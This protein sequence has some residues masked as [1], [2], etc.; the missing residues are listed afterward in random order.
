MIRNFSGN[1]GVIVDSSNKLIA[2]VGVVIHN[3][4]DIESTATINLIKGSDSI[5]IFET[6]LESKESL[7]LDTKIFLSNGDKI[8]VSGANF[9]LSGDEKDV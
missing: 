4:E 9:V 8:E 1:S 2:L 7:F 6:V 3:T 5:Q